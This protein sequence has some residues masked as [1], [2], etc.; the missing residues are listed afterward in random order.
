MWVLSLI[1][2]FTVALL[3]IRSVYEVWEMKGF[4]LRQISILLSPHAAL[5]FG[6][7]VTALTNSRCLASYSL[8]NSSLTDRH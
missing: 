8:L 3:F 2:L 1:V 4:L 7:R 5:F 6:S